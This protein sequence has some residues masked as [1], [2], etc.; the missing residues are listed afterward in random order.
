MKAKKCNLENKYDW[1]CCVLIFHLIELQTFLSL[2]SAIMLI[3][4]H[5]AGREKC[6]LKR[7]IT[8]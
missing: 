7:K 2:S 8:N 4:K 5:S 6:N 1:F 3:L